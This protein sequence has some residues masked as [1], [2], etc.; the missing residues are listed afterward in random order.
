[1]TTD[2]QSK[3]LSW[4]ATEG[5]PFELRVGRAL[6]DAEWDVFHGRH[7]LDPDT[8]KL[9]EIDVHAAF[10]PY[11]GDTRGLGMVSINLVIEC[12]VTS[13]KPWI[14]FTSRQSDDE[15]R[16]AGHLTPG[17]PASQALADALVTNRSKF[18]SF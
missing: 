10:G 3:L 7:Y 17:E 11:V 1:M 15:L 14:V 2:L 18:A 13:A 12:K 16:L 5:Y 9:R 6:H 4:L 8:A